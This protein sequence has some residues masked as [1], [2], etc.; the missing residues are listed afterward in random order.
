VVYAAVTVGLLAA[1]VGIYYFK[2]GL[3]ITPAPPPPPVVTTAHFSYIDGSVKVKTVTSPLVWRDGDTQLP[4]GA[5]D[6]IRTWPQSIAEVTFRDETVVRLSPES[7]ITIEPPTG[8]QKV[9]YVIS[10]GEVNLTKPGGGSARR[11]TTVGMPS[12]RAVVSPSSQADFS[13]GSGYSV[14]R[15]SEGQVDLETTAGDRARVGPDEGVRIDASGKAGPKMRL[16]GVPTLVAPPHQ[17]SVILAREATVRFEWQPVAQAAGYRFMLDRTGTFAA[18]IADNKDLT[19]ASVEVRG[20][21]PGDY[22]WRVA[23]LGLNGVSG[24]FS[25]PSRLNIAGSSGAAP[26]LLL[27]SVQLH[28]NILQVKGKTDPGATVTINGQRLKVESDGSF[29]EMVA[30][31]DPGRQAVVIRAKGLDSEL[32]TEKKV[33]VDV[34]TEG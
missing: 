2:Y 20:L 29:S 27:Q 23:A 9:A 21:D 30:L 22:Y 25:A 19:K 11:P 18:P 33:T 28:S 17:V 15:V 5:G 8:E 1:G 26:D 10:S 6:L 32:F 12:G 7:L 13:V 4:L 34:R 24:R 14:V 16:P 31:K 3:I